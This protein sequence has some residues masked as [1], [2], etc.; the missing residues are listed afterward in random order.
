MLLGFVLFFFYFSVIKLWIGQFRVLWRII[1]Q[2]QCFVEDDFYSGS[3]ENWAALAVFNGG[4]EILR[5]RASSSSFKSIYLEIICLL[6][7][8]V[9]VH[10]GG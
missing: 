2:N 7:F 1:H 5:V 6:S 3:F 9:R 10:L 8:W 4:L